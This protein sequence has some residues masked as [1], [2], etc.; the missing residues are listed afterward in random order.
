MASSNN[1]G[2]YLAIAAIWSSSLKVGSNSL[3]YT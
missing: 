1:G 3:T 2:Y